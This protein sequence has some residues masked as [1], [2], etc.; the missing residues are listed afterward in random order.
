[1]R[2]ASGEDEAE[3]QKKED[4][5]WMSEGSLIHKETRYVKNSIENLQI[6]QHLYPVLSQKEMH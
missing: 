6:S 4:G 2:S 3:A 1:V 5:K